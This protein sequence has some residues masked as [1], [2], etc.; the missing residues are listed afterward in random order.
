MADDPE[1]ARRK[2]PT[3]GSDDVLARLGLT[4]S[5]AAGAAG[6][7]AARRRAAEDAKRNPDDTAERGHTNGRGPAGPSNPDRG[8]RTNGGRPAEPRPPRRPA[9]PTRDAADRGHSNAGGPAGPARTDAGQRGRSNGSGPAD[10]RPQRPTGPARADADQRGRSNGSG[11]AADP[12]RPNADQR[13]HTNGDRPAEP[14][15]SQRPAGPTRDPADQRGHTNGG[16]PAAARRPERSAGSAQSSVDQRG[17]TNGDRPADP[18]PLRPAGLARA[19]AERSGRRTPTDWTGDLTSADRS[20]PTGRVG[21]R[22]LIDRVGPPVD[23]VDDSSSTNRDRPGPI[24]RAEHPA[25]TDRAGRPLPG[26]RADSADRR[27]RP[28]DHGDQADWPTNVIP[29]TTGRPPANPPRPPS[30]GTRPS[31]NPGARPPSADAYPR[32]TTPAPTNGAASRLDDPTRA[33]RG[34]SRDN[35]IDDRTRTA[36]ESFPDAG[37]DDATRA[38]RGPAPDGGV[39]NVT[40]VT[41][42]L[43]PDGG[44]DDPTRTTTRGPSRSS[45]LDDATR[46]AAGPS[47][48]SG[49]DDATRATRTPFRDGGVERRGLGWDGGVDDATRAVRRGAASETAA[50]VRRIDET[51][52][53][54]TLAHAGLRLDGNP[55]EPEE[56]LD[57]RPP[58]QRPSLLRLVALAVTAVVVAAGGVGWGAQRWLG[59]AVRTAS[60]LDP[61]SGA[62]VDPAKQAGAENVLV[63]ATDRAATPGAAARPDT[64]VVAHLSPTAAKGAAGPLTVLSIPT[65]LEV[66]RP[67][68]ERYDVASATYTT[69]TVPAQ[70]RTQLAS[71][72]DLG[73]PRCATRAVQQLT[74]L[75]ITRYVGIDLDRLGAAV[76]AVSGVTVCTPRAVVDASL[77]PVAPTPGSIS[78]DARR[79]TAYTSAAAVAGDPP[80]GQGRIE[81]QQQVLA[82]VLGSTLSETGLLNLPRLRTLR[83]VLG[84]A[85]STDGA[86]LDQVL[87][88]AR[89]MHNLSTGGVTF[90]TV[91]TDPDPT[92]G[93]VLRATDAAAVFDAL[94]TDAA[95]PAPAAGQQNGLKPSDLQVQVRNASEKPGLAAKIAD[96]LRGLGFGIGAVTNADQPTPQTLIHYSPDQTSAAQ[97]LASTVPAATTVADP[98]ATGVLELVL[99]RSFDGVVKAPTSAPTEQAAA[100]APAPVSC[101]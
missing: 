57:D 63:V 76:D 90:A 13:G 10:P 93:S 95:L 89:S 19:D 36:R 101:A 58:R 94:R 78:L 9:D 86:D 50:E 55:D 72:L 99:G 38:T 28:V 41:R 39:D 52:T 15:S 8:G 40:R 32:N 6:G 56:D 4:G 33:T 48:S 80:A 35:G 73:G 20:A 23:W 47:H 1:R 17:R 26:D 25:P 97:L 18:P 82:A 62:I 5:G 44:V 46:A 14:R 66:S 84:G 22:A 69:D 98:G 68:C 92:G 49:L 21:G 54:M 67:P 12:W 70:A 60:A 96:T 34:P 64:V 77:G 100:A 43:A 51:L 2:P 37:P 30:G 61:G 83:P 24:D 11:P 71:A 88:L 85:L 59:S 79:A 3:P 81:R 74:G 75:A 91:P 53:R 42:G 29:V 27:G 31:A 7:R 65:D 87:A 16:G 45:G